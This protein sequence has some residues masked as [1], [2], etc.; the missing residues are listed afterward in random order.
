MVFQAA[1]AKRSNVQRKLVEQHQA[2]LDHA[3]DTVLPSADAAVVRRCCSRIVELQRQTLDLPQTYFMF[4]ESDE[5]SVTNLLF[6]SRA[7]TPGPDVQP[8]VLV[9]RQP[10]LGATAF[11]TSGRR[12]TLAKW[13]ADADK[14]L[15]PRVIVNRVWQYHFGEGLVRTPG[16]FGVGGVE[17]TH[18]QLFDWFV[19]DA[20]WSLKELYRLIVRSS[21]YRMSRDFNDE[22]TAADP[23]NELLWRFPWC[24]LDVEA[25]RDSILA[26]SGRLNR[27]MYGPSV[28]LS[29]PD[30]ILEGHADKVSIWQPFDEPAASRRTIYAFVKRSL[31]VPMREVLDLCGTTRSTEQRSVTGVPTQALTLFNG[32]FVNR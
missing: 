22:Y 3:T 5:I 21:T 27:K 20:D 23:E 18:R 11:A 6:R 16:V 30:Q 29:V 8:A 13:I 15:T 25:I 7:A 9:T 32:D 1:A 12:L 2:A 26:A 4:E 24:R 19:H 17:P 31:I 10:E 14:P 28:Y